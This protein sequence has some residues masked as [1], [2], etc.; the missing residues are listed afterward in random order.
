MLPRAMCMM[1]AILATETAALA[2]SR[3][4][5]PGL[6]HLRIEGPREWS[7]FPETAEASSFE[8]SFEATP[9]A[10][11]ATLRLRQQDVKQTWRVRLNDNV[12]GTL[13]Q[14]E[15]DLVLA[16]PVPAGTLKAGQNALHVEQ[17]T[18]PRA[19]PDDI[20][21][22][23]ITLDSRPLQDVLSEASLNITIT[24]ESKGSTP[25]RITFVDEHGSLTP[26]RVEPS[27][28]LA[29]RTGVI[30]TAEGK[31]RC[32]LPAGKYIIYAGRGFEYSLAKAAVEIAA[33]ETRAVSLSIRREV[34]TD[35]AGSPA[36]RISTRSPTRDTATRAS[37]NEW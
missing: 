27:N 15:S 2:Q 31:A 19:A 29:V 10:G 28:R 4:L 30:Y 16:L 26:L 32:S 24:E 37:K 34:P 13:I 23:E 9:N 6:H 5:D 36:I 8:V 22:G 14:D 33:G 18:G 25:C 1:A 21:L 11:E 7:S 17:Q 3:V 12:L 20:R 35:Q